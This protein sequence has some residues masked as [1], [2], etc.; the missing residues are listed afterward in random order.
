VTKLKLIFFGKL[1]VKLL[2]KNV[3]IFVTDMQNG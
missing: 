1:M 3:T 2:P